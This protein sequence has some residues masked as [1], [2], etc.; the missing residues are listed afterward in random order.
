MPH[1]PYSPRP[2]PPM[3]MAP[4]A[5]PLPRDME[6]VPVPE[7]T[8]RPSKPP[9]PDREVLPTKPR[10]RSNRLKVGLDKISVMSH[11]PDYDEVV[12]FAE[13]GRTT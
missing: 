9:L 11:E 10:K 13:T 3:A 8:P 4:L 12:K 7:E 2:M 6:E 5:T 1:L